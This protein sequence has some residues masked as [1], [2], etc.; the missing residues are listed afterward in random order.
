MFLPNCPICQKPSLKKVLGKK[1]KSKFAALK[2]SSEAEDE[3]VLVQCSECHCYW[4]MTILK[5]TRGSKRLILESVMLNEIIDAASGPKK[6][7]PD[8]ERYLKENGWHK[9]YTENK[10]KEFVGWWHPEISPQS[11][12]VYPDWAAQMIQNGIDDFLYSHLKR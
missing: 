6:S 3:G 11:G 2:P 5:E 1:V 7:A 12:R 4:Q 8:I 10:D 9:I